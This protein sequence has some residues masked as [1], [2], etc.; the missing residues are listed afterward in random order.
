MITYCELC[1]ILELIHTERYKEKI[2]LKQERRME[3]WSKFIDRACLVLDELG[4]EERDV[5][6]KVEVEYEAEK[7]KE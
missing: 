4:D 6:R 7:M 1:Y 2:R 3:E 5:R